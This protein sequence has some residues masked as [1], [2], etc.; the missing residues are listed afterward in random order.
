MSEPH[1]AASVRPAYLHMHRADAPDV[2]RSARRTATCSTPC[3]DGSARSNASA[4]APPCSEMVTS[5]VL[6]ASDVA[7][8]VGP[9]AVE[10]PQTARRP[11][12]ARM[13]A[14]ADP[15][16]A[17]ASWGRGTAGLRKSGGGGGSGAARGAPSVVEAASYRRR[18]AGVRSSLGGVCGRDRKPRRASSRSIAC[19]MCG[20]VPPSAASAPPPAESCSVAVCRGAEP[21]ASVWPQA[22]AGGGYRHPA[23]RVSHGR[24]ATASEW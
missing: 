5:V 23:V 4:C 14:E 15:A 7:V 13:S 8:S 12:I 10:A 19:A 18:F 16:G 6:M 2:R 1:A 22:A 9:R 3:L 11:S 20:T 21:D 17:S 24:R